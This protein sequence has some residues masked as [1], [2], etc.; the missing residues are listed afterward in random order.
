MAAPAIEPLVANREAGK[1]FDLIERFPEVMRDAVLLRFVRTGELLGKR[2]I[3]GNAA[4]AA[5]GLGPVFSRR[6]VLQIE[7]EGVE[8]EEAEDCERYEEPGAHAQ[9]VARLPV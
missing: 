3:R 1:A 8:P 5:Y 2:L 6:S 9:I 7:H 4:L